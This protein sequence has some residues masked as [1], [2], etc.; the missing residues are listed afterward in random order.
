MAARTGSRL[1]VFLGGELLG[2][3]ERRGPARYRFEYADSALRSGPAGAVVLSASLPLRPEAFGPSQAAPYF[4]GLLPEGSVRTAIARSL[5]ISEQDGF[6]LLEAIGAE[7]AGAVAVLPQ[8]AAPKPPGGGSLR[9]LEA[10][11]LGKMIEDLPRNPLGVSASPDG[12]RLSLGG[13][14]HKLVLSRRPRGSARPHPAEFSLPLD[15]APSTCLLKPELGEYED[16]ATNELFCMRI[17]ADAQ[18]RVAHSDLLR[19]GSTTCLYVER[20]DRMHREGEIM[21][22]HQEDMC[23]AL[24][25]L[26][27]AKYEENGGPSL[28][29]I[30]GLLRR[31]RGSFMAR[32]I[33]DL[34]HAALVNFLV[35]NSDAHG[36]NFALLY[37]R[38]AGVRLAPLYDLVSTAVYPDVTDRMAMRIGG[39]G[40]PDRVDIESWRR[41]A[42]ECGL[43]GGIAPLIRR[44]TASVLRSAELWREAAKLEGWHRPV[45]DAI[46]DVCHRRAGQLTA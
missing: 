4:E 29:G 13:V 37:E 15:G 1:G 23:Q 34:I 12:A 17:A 38:D 18:L 35:G 46:V 8:G 7:C 25:V 6:G 44:R 24:G 27:A 14:Q 33:N 9:L 20:F 32:D 11:E 30:V 26:P 45:I 21:R 2:E 36:K 10:E 41:L 42:E 16:L 3:L 22:I 5:R 40:D 43:G 19:V 39:V 31:L 28:A